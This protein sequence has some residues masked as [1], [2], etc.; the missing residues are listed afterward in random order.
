MKIATFNIWNSDRG[1]P[2]RE[3][4]IINEIKSVDSDIICLQEVKL[5][6]YTKLKDELTDYSYN[7]YHDADDECDGMAV[8]CKTPILTN[9]HTNCAVYST[10]EFEN[11]IYLIVNVHL[12]WDSISKKEEYIVE[13][14]NTITGINADYAILTGDFNCS[15]HSSVHHY[16]T[17]QRTLLNAETQPCWCDLAEVHSEC[18][19]TRLE[20]TLDLVNNPRWKGKA[21]TE[22]SQRFDRI[23]IRDTYPKP[24]PQLKHF[25]LFGKTIDEQSEYCASDHY[26]VVAEISIV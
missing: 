26:G 16:L 5:E 13:I 10:Y 17:G 7:Y 3:Q 21:V 19:N 11:N 24:S 4:Q 15:G 23:Y 25:A 12:P 6:A 8:F 2:L 18:S 14:N 22:T 9:H 1:M 20:V